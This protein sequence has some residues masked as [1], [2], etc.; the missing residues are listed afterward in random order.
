[1]RRK[2][3][4]VRI[5]NSIQEIDVSKWD[6]VAQEFDQHTVFHLMPWLRTITA[7]FGPKLTLLGAMYGGEWQ[8]VWPLLSLRKGPFKVVGSPLPGWSTAYL[9]PLF[10]SSCDPA[11]VVAD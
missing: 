4:M 1:M 11:A 7:T 6:D 8:A 10:K 9:G 5:E 3:Q 2:S